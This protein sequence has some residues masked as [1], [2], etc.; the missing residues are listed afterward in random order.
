MYCRNALDEYGDR[1]NHQYQNVPALRITENKHSG[2]AFRDP[3]RFETVEIFRFARWYNMIGVFSAT[4]I[5]VSNQMDV[6]YLS[7]S[8]WQ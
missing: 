8:N 7:S 6:E 5:V 2:Y 1:S 4:K 3:S